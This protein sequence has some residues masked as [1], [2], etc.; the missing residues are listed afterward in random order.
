MYENPSRLRLTSAR[1]YPS[2][3]RLQDGS[4]LILGGMVAGGFNNAEA[5]D[6]PTFEFF[7]PKGNGLQFYSKFLHDALNSNL[8]P[9]TYLL[10]DGNIFVAANKIAMIYNWKTNKERRLPGIPNSV[11]VTYPGEL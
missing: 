2:T 11:T 3:V 8:F 5:T 10:P 4:L 7:P 9:I 6:N 1:W